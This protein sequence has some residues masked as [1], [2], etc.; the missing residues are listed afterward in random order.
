MTPE[1]YK[2]PTPYTHHQLGTMIGANR[3]A[4]TRAFARLRETGAVETENRTIEI[5]DIVALQKAAEGVS[6]IKA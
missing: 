6:P 1:G 2:I 3:E 4:V 5:P